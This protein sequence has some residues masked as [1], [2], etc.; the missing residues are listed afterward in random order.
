MPFS[1]GCRP[2][3]QSRLIIMILIIDLIDSYNT[4]NTC[5]CNFNKVDTNID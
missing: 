1:A 3:A 4:Y 2:R 5:L